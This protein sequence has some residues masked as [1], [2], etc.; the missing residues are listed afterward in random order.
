MIDVEQVASTVL[1]VGA[2]ALVRVE[3]GTAVVV[4]PRNTVG[5]I[6]SM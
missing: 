6:R 2:S 4:F 1:F 3:A 5:S